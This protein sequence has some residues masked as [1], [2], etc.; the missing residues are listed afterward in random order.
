MEVAGPESAV[1]LKDWLENTDGN[2]LDPEVMTYPTLRVIASYGDSGTVAY[3]PSQQAIVLML[4]S[5][6][7]NPKAGDLEKGQAFRDLVKGC[8]LLASS[9]KI[10]E[11]YFFC[12]DD[13]VLKIAEGHGF[14][15]LPWTAVRM[16]LR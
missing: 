2:L 9:F 5:L 16:K 6:A 7:T 1:E 4:E 13:A 11:L 10:K 14:E 15:R 3:L 12:K 8:E